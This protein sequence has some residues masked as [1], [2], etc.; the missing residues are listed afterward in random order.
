MKQVAYKNILLVED[1]ADLRGAIEAHFAEQNNVVACGTLTAAVDALKAEAFDVILLDVI[2]PDGSGLKLLEYTH[3]VPVVILSDL[4]EDC[5]IL[6]GLSAGAVDYIVKPVSLEVLDAR[7]SLR[8]LSDDKAQLVAH[9]LTLNVAKRTAVYKGK[10]FEL[11]SSEFNILHFLM[12][13]AGTFF[14]ANEIY[15]QVWHMPHLNTATIKTHLS[16]LR[17]KMFAVSESCAAL[18]ISEFGKGY[19]FIGKSVL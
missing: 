13:N 10:P 1:D 6:D 2:L 19:A 9:G 8:L 12:R 14:T 7:V 18:I 16:N 3:A 11:T 5:H 15:E 17:K 4:G